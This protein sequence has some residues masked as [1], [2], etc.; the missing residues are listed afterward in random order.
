MPFFDRPD[1]NGTL[2]VFSDFWVFWVIAVPITAAT[3]AVWYF[4][5]KSVVPPLD[6]SSVRV[7][8]KAEKEPSQFYVR[9][10]RV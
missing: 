3:V 7:A 9:R 5:Q 8:S 6:M 1:T 2:Q 10:P 4:W